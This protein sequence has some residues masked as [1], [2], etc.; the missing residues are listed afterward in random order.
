MTPASLEADL[1]ALLPRLCEIRHDIHKH[2]E[3]GF[4]EHRTQRLVRQWLEGLGLEAKDCASTGLVC[5]IVGTQ[6]GRT[7]AL[8][9]DLDALPMHEHT[10]LDYR[11]VHDGVA[12]KCGHDG[13]TAI[14]LGTAALLTRRRNAGE[15]AGRV[16][17]IFQPAEEGVDGGGA[18]VMVDE[19]VLD[20]VDEIY[21][22]HNWPA[23]ARGEVRVCAGPIMAQV[24][25]FETRITGKGG[26][27]SQPQ[28]CRDPIVAGAALVSALQTLV[29][30]GLASHE[31]AILSVGT[32]HAGEANN[33]I[34]DRAILSGTIRCFDAD[35]GARLER[36]FAEVCAGVAATHGVEIEPG[37][38]AGYPVLINDADC[39]QAVE[40]VARACVGPEACS[41]AALPLTAAEDFAYFTQRRPGAYFFLGAGDPRDPAQTPGCHHPDFDFDDLLIETGMR[42]FTGLVAARTAA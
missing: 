26:H 23:F 32:F 5:D 40:H 2:P 16:R 6:P 35:V 42:M 15:L 14:L 17:L 24:Y 19:G 18:R 39:A 34:P 28:A 20:G 36:R 22:L 37:L 38:E 21:G 4:A 7:I 3:L 30:R 25:E 12:H 27:A 33:V 11:S 8:R 9:A 31:A 29:S 41:S 13:H 1:Q 10:A